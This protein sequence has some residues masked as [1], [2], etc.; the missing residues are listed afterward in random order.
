MITY[1]DCMDPDVHKLNVDWFI[2]MMY[3]YFVM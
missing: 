2:D 1:M 3:T